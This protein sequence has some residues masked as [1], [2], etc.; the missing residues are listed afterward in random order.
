MII[1]ISPAWTQL[2]GKTRT[3]MRKSDRETVSEAKDVEALFGRGP[4][5]AGSLLPT[6]FL[7]RH[8]ETVLN[9]S[10]RLRGLS[11]PDL[12]AAGREEAEALATT[13]APTRP[14][15]I[16][17]SPLRRTLQ[18]AEAIAAAC[19]LT[20]EM[21]NDLIDRDFGPQNG[22]LVDEVTATWGS[23]DDAPG[24]E[25][26][27]SVLARA[28]SALAKATTRTMNGGVVLV[29]HDAVNSALLASLDPGRWPDPSAVSQPTGCFN[30]L[31]RDDHTWTVVIAGLKPSPPHDRTEVP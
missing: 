10:G 26:W 11:D 27:E 9:A 12:D 17:A 21:C 4:D 22:R 15:A 30:V 1:P 23:V 7:C 29:S 16:V 18:T 31:Q 20:V 24:V 13:L 3:F 19:A 2:S 25:P 14:V 28:Q 6:I 8:G 5:Q